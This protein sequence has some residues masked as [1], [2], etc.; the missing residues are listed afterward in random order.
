MQKTYCFD[1]DILQGHKFVSHIIFPH[2]TMNGDH[3]VDTISHL[4]VVHKNYCFD[5][6]FRGRFARSQNTLTH[7][8]GKTVTDL[9]V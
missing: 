2:Y 5:F 8:R 7:E 3:S 4:T 1:I 9:T 6:D